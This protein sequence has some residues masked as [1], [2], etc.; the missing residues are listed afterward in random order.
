MAACFTPAH[1]ASGSAI[2]R[3]PSRRG[4]SPDPVAYSTALHR[5]L[6]MTTPERLD[7]IARHLA[8]AWR[9]G[10]AW[11]VEQHDALTPE[12]S[13]AIQDRVAR[14]LEWFPDGHPRAWKAGGNPTLTAA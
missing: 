1:G 14:L 5:S 12:D 13:Y 7:Q 11:T 8:D 10:R 6:S 2:R 3:A 4:A 9:S